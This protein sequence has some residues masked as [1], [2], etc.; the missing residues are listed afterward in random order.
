MKCNVAKPSFQAKYSS[1]VVKAYT[2]VDL[3]PADSQGLTLSSL[4]LAASIDQNRV[5]HRRDNVARNGMSGICIWAMIM[6]M[7]L[8]HQQTLSR[9]AKV[10]RTSDSYSQTLITSAITLHAILCQV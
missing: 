4:S 10:C 7:A 2:D 8:M 5:E 6:A 9:D 1:A 3:G